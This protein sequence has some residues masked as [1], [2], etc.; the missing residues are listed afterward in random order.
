MLRTI[1]I[2][3]LL[4]TALLALF[5][6]S[7]YSM[8]GQFAG[9]EVQVV[10]FGSLF[11]VLG[12]ILG[13]QFKRKQEE[14]HAQPQAQLSPESAG[15]SKREYEVLEQIAMGK[16]NKE[17]A[18]TLFVSESTVKS[19]VSNLLV[20]LNARRRTEAVKLAQDMGLLPK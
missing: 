6:L 2:F 20:K 19:H 12:L 7:K 13:K 1:I 3:G 11:V 5:E 14:K 4:A 18:E 10:I 16:S 8:L 17:I 9:T 15:V